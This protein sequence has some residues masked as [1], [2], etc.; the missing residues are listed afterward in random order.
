MPKLHLIAAALGA[1]YAAPAI[2]APAT[3]PPIASAQAPDPEQLALAAR[4][5]ATLWPDG[6]YGRMFQS[7]MGG[8]NGLFDM[9]LDLRPADLI[10]AMAEGMAKDAAP[11]SPNP[12]AKSVKPAASKPSPTLRETMRAED[13]HFEERMRITATVVGEEMT[14]LAKPIEPKMRDGLT[15][16]IA[17]RFTREQL[18][19]IAAFF[20]TAAG[21]AYAAQSLN[22]FIDKDVILALITSVPPLFKEVPGVMEKVKKATAHLPPPPK[23]ESASDDGDTGGGD[24]GSA[25]QPDELPST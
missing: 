2:A 16:S 22:L 11:G 4:V 19:P 1:A 7:M 12:E 23:P 5:S 17:R 25:D 14:R 20:D 21:K 13:P 3:A 10:G 8:E 18:A 9:V 6:T 24:P 15:K